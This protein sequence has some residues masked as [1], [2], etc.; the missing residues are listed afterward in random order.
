MT[1]AAAGGISREA[2][3]A[4]RSKPVV[5][6]HIGLP[7]VREPRTARLLATYLARIAESVLRRGQLGQVY[8][9]GG[10]TAIELVRR[11][12]WGRLTVLREVAP[13]VA[14]LRVADAPSLCLTVKPGSYAWPNQIRE[15]TCLNYP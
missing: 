14:T 9:E 10:A 13:G 3:A 4:Q 6:L 15:L 2:L 11:M 1:A 8:V 5:I 7:Q 12:G